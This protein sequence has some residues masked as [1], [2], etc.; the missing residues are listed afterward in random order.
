MVRAPDAGT[1]NAAAMTGAQLVKE[2]ERREDVALGNAYAIAVAL[3]ELSKPARY[4]EEL[5]FES[6]EE[7]LEK[8]GLSSRMTAHKHVT[9]VNVLSEKEVRWI[10]LLICWVLRQDANADPRKVLAPGFRVGGMLVPELS[11]RDLREALR[12]LGSGGAPAVPATAATT[13]RGAQRLR[14]AFRRVRIAAAVRAHTRDEQPHVSARMEPNAAL[15]LAQV[16]VASKAGS[17]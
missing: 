8:K 9:V 4:K 15:R 13:K 6:V 3:M 2:V 1:R 5:G 7:L 16:L 17:T 12:R 14:G 10:Y 11:V